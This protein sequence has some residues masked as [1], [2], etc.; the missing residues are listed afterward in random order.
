MN[1][2]TN[3]SN[4]GSKYNLYDSNPDEIST[5]CTTIAEKNPEK[6]IDNAKFNISGTVTSE[7]TS[8]GANTIVTGTEIGSISSDDG[9][10]YGFI[11]I[12]VG[13][14]IPGLKKTIKNRAKASK[15]AKDAKT[16]GEE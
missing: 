9:K 15:I 14:L 2:G 6:N 3:P 12:P 16:I 1:N 10:K 13:T 5:V 7:G 11:T 4:E 8:A